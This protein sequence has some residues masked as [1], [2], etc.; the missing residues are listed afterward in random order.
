MANEIDSAFEIANFKADG[1]LGIGFKDVSDS[2]ENS[3][4]QNFFITGQLVNG[5]PLIGIDLDPSNPEVVIGG[6]NPQFAN[7]LIV[8]DQSASVSILRSSPGHH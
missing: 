1:S 8:V 2:G 5:K 7:N 6:T 4:F 3:V